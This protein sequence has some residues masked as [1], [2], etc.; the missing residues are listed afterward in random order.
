MVESPCVSLLEICS[1]TSSYHQCISWNR[2]I[3]CNWCF[4]LAFCWLWWLLYHITCCV[5]TAYIFLDHN[6]VN[7][8]SICQE[9]CLNTSEA[10]S[11]RVKN[12]SHTPVGVP[13][14]TPSF[15]LQIP[16]EMILEGNVFRMNLSETLAEVS[17]S[18]N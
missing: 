8:S 3:I 11:V 17:Y 7:H 16:C 5:H 14:S 15:Q 18:S 2:T 1:T 4:I 9:C 6:L 13:G 12:E 10:H